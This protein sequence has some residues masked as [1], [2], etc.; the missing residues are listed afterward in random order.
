MSPSKTSTTP[1][2]CST[3]RWASARSP[4]SIPCSTRCGRSA[5]CTRGCSTSSS[6]WRRRWP[7]RWSATRVPYA[8]L[9]FDAVQQVLKDGE[10][11]SSSGYA[12]SI[13]LVMGHSI[14]EM[15]EPEHHRY[16]S[17]I[18]QAF[19]RKE[20][21]RWERELVT[22]IVDGLIDEFA[23]RGSA[24]LMRELFFPFPVHVIAGMLGLP[25]RGPHAVPPQGRRA[26]HHHGR[27]RAGA[28]GVAVA[29]RL[30]RRDHRRAPRRPAW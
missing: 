26:D 10:T 9:S 18:Q 1:S 6:A 23:D 11:F 20:M 28:R 29:L 4:T 12:D 22:P 15:D 19:T 17:L 2:P 14:L 16:R 8:V 7:T 5:R 27:D 13:G 21:E 25:A 3:S 24:E 30:L